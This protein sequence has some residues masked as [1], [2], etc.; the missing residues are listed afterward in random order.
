[1]RCWKSKGLVLL[2]A[3]AC[4]SLAGR[5]HGA[6]VYLDAN[7]ATNTG[8]AAAFTAGTNDNADDNLWSRRTTFGVNGDIFQSGDGNGE[9]APEIVTTI[10]G[11]I[12][13]AAYRVYVHFW[14]GSGTAPD[15]NIRGGFAPG[16]NTLFA[17]PADA[18]DIGATAAVLASSLTYV[19]NPT[20]FTEADRTQYAGLI[21]TASASGLGTLAVYINDLPSTIGV[22]NRS[23]YDGVSYE[24]VPEPA[25]VA[26]LMFA[27]PTLA[28]LRRRRVA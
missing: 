15:W 14:D 26:M 13:L 11:L 27:A 25:S 4:L 21:G 1:M 24:M 20:P 28:A 12:P 5:S 9:D 6:L 3:G 16:V 10:P 7:K 22:N 23:W 8:A 19:T 2:A 18:A 17:N